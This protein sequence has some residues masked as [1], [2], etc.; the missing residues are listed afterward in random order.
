[1]L[2][3]E[4]SVSFL[5]L[6]AHVLFAVEDAVS[7]PEETPYIIQPKVNIIFIFQNNARND[8]SLK[9]L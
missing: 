6:F 5:D 9:S 7:N 2:L 3:K 1:M 8:K 4:Y